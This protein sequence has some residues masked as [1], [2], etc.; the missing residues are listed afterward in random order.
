MVGTCSN[1]TTQHLAAVCNPAR[2]QVSPDPSPYLPLQA[3][4]KVSTRRW[5]SSDSSVDMLRGLQDCAGYNALRIRTVI[6]PTLSP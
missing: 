1:S 6:V 3:E 5:A 2:Q 4:E